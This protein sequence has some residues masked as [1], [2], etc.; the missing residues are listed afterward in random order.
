MENES[1]TPAAGLSGP[2]L[3]ERV[4]EAMGWERCRGGYRMPREKGERRGRIREICEPSW[5]EDTLWAIEEFWPIGDGNNLAEVLAECK[6]R[7]WDWQCRTD[8]VGK[9]YRFEASVALYRDNSRAATGYTFPVAFLR[10]FVAA[11]EASQQ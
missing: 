10:A 3:C 9:Q 11:A 2:E 1:K 8:T 4:A 7:N 5:D 6:Q